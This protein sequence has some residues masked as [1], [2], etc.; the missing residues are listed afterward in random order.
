MKKILLIALLFSITSCLD[1][2]DIDNTT[3]SYC[4][5][6]DPLK[7][8]IWLK[9]IKS[10]FEQSTSAPKKKIIQY[11]YNNQRVFLIDSC[12]DCA[13]NLIT[14]Y[15][16]NGTKICEFGGIQGLNTC[17]DFDEN[18]TNKIILWEN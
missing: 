13:D 5:T 9:Q 3:S 17:P 4:E 7:D 12:V 1:L 6:A 2:A 8:L 18:A 11:I 16:C 14:V 10:N 15:N